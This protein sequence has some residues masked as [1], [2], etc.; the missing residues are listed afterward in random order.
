MRGAVAADRNETTLADGAQFPLLGLGV[1]QVP[2]DASASTQ[3]VGRSN[4]ATGTSTPPRPTATRRASGRDCAKA[5]SRAIT[6]S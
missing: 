2:K 1:W 6:C 5:V 3:S 4:S